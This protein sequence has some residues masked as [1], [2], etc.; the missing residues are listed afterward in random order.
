MI[1]PCPIIPIISKNLNK[2]GAV[3]FFEHNKA[4]FNGSPIPKSII[5]KKI[6][7][8][9]ISSTSLEQSIYEFK[10]VKNKY[11]G[12]NVVGKYICLNANKIGDKNVNRTYFSL[13]SI[14]ILLLH[15]LSNEKQ[16]LVSEKVSLLGIHFHL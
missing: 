4:K 1:P 13:F 5:F 6:T 11:M 7:P 15:A 12:Y 8:N 2:F 3:G 9:K 16:L 14:Q 10:A